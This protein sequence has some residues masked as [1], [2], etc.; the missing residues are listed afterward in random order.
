MLYVTGSYL[1]KTDFLTSIDLIT[2]V[3]VAALTP[4]TEAANPS[5]TTLR[6]LPYRRPSPCSLRAA[7]SYDADLALK[8]RPGD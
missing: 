4:R 8:P 7:A 1:P 2:I 5:V 6:F 3:S